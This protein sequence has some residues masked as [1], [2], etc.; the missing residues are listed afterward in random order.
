MR[1]ARFPAPNP[2]VLVIGDSVAGLTT[3]WTLLDAGYVATVL[4]D[5]WAPS[6]LHVTRQVAGALFVPLQLFPSI[7][8]L[9]SRHID[10]N[11]PCR[12]WQTH[13]R[14]FARAFRG[15]VLDGQQSLTL[16]PVLL[17]RCTDSA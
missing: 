9:L 17:L 1:R 12:M 14:H 8:A 7:Y 16:S 3:T 10:G 6:I 15:L 4:S 13:W 11:I 5:Q 2:R